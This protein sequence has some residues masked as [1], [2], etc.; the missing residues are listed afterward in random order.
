M[1]WKPT[2]I[3]AARRMPSPEDAR[4]L[5]NIAFF[6]G[7][8]LEKSE[9]T[10]NPI[11]NSI[12]V[13]QQKVKFGYIRVYC[14]LLCPEKLRAIQQLNDNS[15][16]GNTL[17]LIKKNYFLDACAHYRTIYRFFMQ[18]FPN[19]RDRIANEADYSYLLADT[20]F[21]MYKHCPVEWQTAPVTETDFMNM[22]SSNEKINFHMSRWPDMEEVPVTWKEMLV[23][24]GFIDRFAKNK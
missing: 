21:E 11:E 12:K 8:G 20:A 9:Y 24:L 5:T 10:Q 2:F 3:D 16:I 4:V 13:Y 15:K 18:N 19:L 14:D 1:D 22:V 6:I 23:N 7:A 17:E